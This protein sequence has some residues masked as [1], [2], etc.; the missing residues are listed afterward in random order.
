VRRRVGDLVRHLWKL[1][2][3][4]TNLWRVSD[5]NCIVALPHWSVYR[6]F[7]MC[8]NYSPKV[9][10]FIKCLPINMPSGRRLGATSVSNRWIFWSGQAGGGWNRHRFWQTANSFPRPGTCTTQV[11]DSEIVSISNQRG[12]RSGPGLLQSLRKRHRR[13]CSSCQITAE[14]AQFVYGQGAQALHGQ[15]AQLVRR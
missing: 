10:R 3:Y 13:R 12:E 7:S 14:R 1:S 5:S 4:G 9:R 11:L 6:H 15:S 8:P 2:S